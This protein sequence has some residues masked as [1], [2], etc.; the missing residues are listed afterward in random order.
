MSYVKHHLFIKDEQDKNFFH[1]AYTMYLTPSIEPFV[2]EYLLKK[3][4]I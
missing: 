1:S 2:V 3:I 4:K